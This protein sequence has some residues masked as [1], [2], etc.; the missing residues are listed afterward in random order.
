MYI[1][2][3]MQVTRRLVIIPVESMRS[4]IAIV[5]VNKLKIDF[6]S[7]R[8]PSAVSGIKRLCA[9][10]ISGVKIVPEANCLILDIL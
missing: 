6:I 9:T 10:I 5:F 4:D 3:I 8:S 2:I 1:F 7:F